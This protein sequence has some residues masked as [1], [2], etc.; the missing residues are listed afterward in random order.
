MNSISALFRNSDAFRNS[1][2][3]RNSV[4][5]NMMGKRVHAVLVRL[6]DS[7]NRVLVVADVDDKWQRAGVFMWEMVMFVRAK[8][9]EVTTA[10]RL[11][12]LQGI[13]GEGWEVVVASQDG[14]GTMHGVSAS[15]VLH[16]LVPYMKVCKPVAGLEGWNGGACCYD[17]Y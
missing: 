16:K 9:V 3:L 6:G 15:N 13:L 10:E 11:D 12:V 7:G 8:R 2:V 17:E 1:V 5:Q 4:F 14:C